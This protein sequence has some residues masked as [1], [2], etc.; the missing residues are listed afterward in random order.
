MIVHVHVA[1]VIPLNIHVSLHVHVH[2]CASVIPLNIHVHVSLH[3]HVASVIPPNISLHVHSF[4]LEY[5]FEIPKYGADTCMCLD[6]C[7]MGLQGMSLY[8]RY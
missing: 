1:S 4:M 7:M 3:V 2:T 8:I 6:L 5:A